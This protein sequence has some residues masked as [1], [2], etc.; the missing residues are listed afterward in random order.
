MWHLL[1]PPGKLILLKVLR[2]LQWERGPRVRMAVVAVAA[3]AA[4]A[5]TAAA[6]NGQAAAAAAATSSAPSA[7]AARWPPTAVCV[8]H[9][10]RATMV[11][12]TR[13]QRQVM[14]LKMNDRVTT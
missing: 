4:A 10:D 7:Q 5:A 14:M 11:S 3:A 6:A 2:N 12:T 1:S 13:E 8:A 9:T